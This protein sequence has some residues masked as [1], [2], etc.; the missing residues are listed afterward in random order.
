MSNSGD[1]P[2]PEP[3]QLALSNIAQK[4]HNIWF[5]GDT[6]IDVECAINSGCCPILFGDQP[7]GG[8]VNDEG[9]HYHYASNNCKL[10][11]LSS[12]LILFLTNIINSL[13]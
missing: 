12:I 6:M 1:K 13:F 5:V 11:A 7:T 3:V 9:Y 8:V 10:L 4:P 2:Q